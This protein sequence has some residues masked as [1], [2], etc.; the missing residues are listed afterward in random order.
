MNDITDEEDLEKF[1]IAAAAGAYNEQVLDVDN[2]YRPQSE[3]TSKI[4]C[5]E[6]PEQEVPID[7]LCDGDLPTNIH[8]TVAATKI[9]EGMFIP[10]IRLATS[11]DVQIR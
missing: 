10:D 11:M 3:V 7:T 5:P 1:V 8:Y 9:Y 4:T 2:E 6:N